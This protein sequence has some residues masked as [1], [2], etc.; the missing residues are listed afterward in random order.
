MVE[1]IVW[2][3]VSDAHEIMT[4]LIIVMNYLQGVVIGFSLQ[5]HRYIACSQKFVLLNFFILFPSCI[6]L[7]LL[8]CFGFFFYLSSVE[9]SSIVAEISCAGA[10]EVDRNLVIVSQYQ[11][12]CSCMSPNMCTWLLLLLKLLYIFGVSLFVSYCSLGLG[13]LFFLFADV[14]S[15]LITIK[16]VLVHKVISLDD[17]EWIHW[18]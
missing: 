14:S 8:S 6:S 3:F 5:F 13:F 4:A 9:L 10:D 18:L 17:L 16:G 2:Y 15:D 7:F 11:T 1:E 12:C